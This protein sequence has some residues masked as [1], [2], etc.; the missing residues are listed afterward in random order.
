MYER[1]G[2]QAQV[3]FQWTVGDMRAHE[4]NLTELVKHPRDYPLTIASRLIAYAATFAVAYMLLPDARFS[5]I[6]WIAV[7]GSLSVWIAAW[8]EILSLRTLERLKAQDPSRVG[9]NWVWLD[10]SGIVWST[11]T[12]EEYTSWLGVIDVIENDETLWIQTGHVNGY[13]LPTS[14]FSSSDE[15]HDCRRLITRLR[16]HPLPP[17]HLKTA[18]DELIKH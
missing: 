3:S 16:E 12:S 18:G 6:L 15:F 14:A 9:W 5:T 11:E 10:S 17:A 8:F 4:K 13:F 1:D 2:E 7:A